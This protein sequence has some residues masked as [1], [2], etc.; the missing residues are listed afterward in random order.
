MMIRRYVRTST[1]DVIT[2]L[3]SRRQPIPTSLQRRIVSIL[4]ASYIVYVVYYFVNYM[5]VCPSSYRRSLSPP[6]AR[7]SFCNLPAAR[8]QCKRDKRKWFYNKETSACETFIY[9]GWFGNMNCFSSKR[10]CRRICRANR[11]YCSPHTS[12]IYCK[13][14]FHHDQLVTILVTFASE[15]VEINSK[16]CLSNGLLLRKTFCLYSYANVLPR[17]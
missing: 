1:H 3:K 9:A 14:G 4:R 13:S 8:G 7:P 16:H 5:S 2:M 12:A 15:C 10:A 6:L 11:R 17:I